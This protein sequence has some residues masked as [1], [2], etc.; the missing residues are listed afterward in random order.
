MPWMMVGQFLLKNWK[1][2]LIG[3]GVLALWV[4]WQRDRAAMFDKGWEAGGQK[5][6]DT[7]EKQY[8]D[9]WAVALKGIEAD[10]K[11]VAQ[12]QTDAETK[13]KVTQAREQEL[14]QSRR[15]IEAAA[16]NLEATARANT[17]AAYAAGKNLTSDN[18]DVALRELSGKLEA[19]KRLRA[20]GSP[21]PVNP[22]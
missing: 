13:I 17:E 4:I 1:Y 10:G 7:L 22:K 15:A 19:D 18:A 2:A 20:S 5:M 11:R 16:R 12:L 3:V 14:A 8:K 21:C 6:Q 9:K